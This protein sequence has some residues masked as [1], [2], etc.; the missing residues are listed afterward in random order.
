M[1]KGKRKLAVQQAKKERI[2]KKI[3]GT[4]DRPRLCVKRSLSH[5]YVQAVDDLSARSLAQVSS[6]SKEIREKTGVK[7]M[8]KSKLCGNLI[9]EKLLSLGIKK[10]VFD[11]G[12][13]PYHGRIKAIAD[14]AR[15]K[16][17]QF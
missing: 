5:V 1:D 7:K 16:G 10:V 13:Y 6:H 2:R 11:R 12:G 3:S 14:G 17:L 15:E 9:A 4:A 8:E